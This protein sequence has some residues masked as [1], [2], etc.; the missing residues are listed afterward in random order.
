MVV[1]KQTDGKIYEVIE[2]SEGWVVAV[3]IGND[4]IRKAALTPG[5]VTDI[6]RSFGLPVG[7]KDVA[8]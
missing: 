3:R 1:A 5:H 2:L 6:L 4:Y 8:H 7:D